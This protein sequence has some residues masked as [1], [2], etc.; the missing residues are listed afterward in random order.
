[1]PKTLRYSIR[2]PQDP[3]TDTWV[4]KMLYYVSISK[5]AR[6]PNSDYPF[7]PP[8]NSYCFLALQND[9]ERAFIKAV[10]PSAEVPKTI[11][12]KFPYPMVQEDMFVAF[13][14]ILFPLLLVICM[15]LSMK[16]TIKVSHLYLILLAVFL[17]KLNSLLKFPFIIEI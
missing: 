9:I 6:E 13:A 4:T 3:A 12:Q 11:L 5:T 10:K 8:Y 14:S 17:L 1:M 16:N 15:L 2:L 7:Q